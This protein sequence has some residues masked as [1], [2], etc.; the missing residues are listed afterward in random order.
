MQFKQTKKGEKTMSRT[1]SMEV[2]SIANIEKHYHD[3]MRHHLRRWDKVRFCLSLS[4]EQVE[5]LQSLVDADFGGRFVVE[6]KRKY[7]WVTEKPQ[8]EDSGCFWDLIREEY[9]SEDAFWDCHI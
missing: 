4:P 9:G 6:Q 7:L 3:Q 5:I 8:Y 1:K 2:K